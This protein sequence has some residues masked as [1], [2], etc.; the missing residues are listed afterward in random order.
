MTAFEFRGERFH[1]DLSDDEDEKHIPHQ[2]QAF[3]RNPPPEPALSFVKDVLERAS[4]KAPVAPTLNPQST[5]FPTHKKRTT[6]SRFKK[7]RQMPQPDDQKHQQGPPSPPPQLANNA[8]TIPPQKPFRSTTSDTDEARERRDI[9]AQNKKTLAGMSESEIEMEREELMQGLT[10]AMLQR[11]LKRSTI[12]DPTMNQSWDPPD[13]PPSQPVQDSKPARKVAFVDTMQNEEPPPD[14]ARMPDT[15]DDEHDNLDDP[16]PPALSDL[17]ITSSI[18]FPHA[19]PAPALDPSSPSFLADL[20]TKYF[21]SLPSDPSKLAWMTPPSTPSPYS[22]T[23]SHLPASALRFDFRG[24]LLPPRTSLAIPVTAGL[25]HHGD[26]PDAAGYTL[27][28]LAHL[29]RSAVPSQR[30]IAYQT[31]GR[32]LYRLGRGEWGVVRGGGLGPTDGDGDDQAEMARGLWRCIEE[33]RVLDTL[34]DEAGREAGG[35][36]SARAYA[37][38]ALWNWQRGG[39]KKVVAQ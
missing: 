9:D 37:V 23:L 6:Q 33:G 10:P 19:P 15:K 26:A 30:C 5:G 17:P 29:A 20:H 31:L 35:H 27:P 13:R 24:T 28:E 21:P 7:E 4:A 16:P 8:P 25:H 32:L 3:R 14:T 12:D 39:G 2:Q 11:L 38:E 18:H 34:H 1:I 36:V 22:P